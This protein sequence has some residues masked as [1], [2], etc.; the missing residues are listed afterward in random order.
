MLAIRR[1]VEID[2][3]ATEKFTTY[4]IGEGGKVLATSFDT[5]PVYE[6]KGNEKYVRV[7]VDSSF[8]SSAWTQP[9]Y[10]R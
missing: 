5:I 7:R 1:R 2:A 10:L 3:R 8:G 6:I 4:F 9:L